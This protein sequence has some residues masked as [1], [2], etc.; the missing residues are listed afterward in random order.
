MKFCLFLLLLAP[1]A[2]ATTQPEL[3][4][5]LAHVAAVHDRSDLTPVVI[6]DLDETLI[7]STPR[8]CS[9][10]HQAVHDYCGASR[11]DDCGKAFALHLADFE[12]LTNRYD[13]S[14][15]FDRIELS[16]GFRR[17][18]QSRALNYYLSEQFVS[19]DLAIPGAV[20]YLRELRSRGAAVFFVTARLDRDVWLATMKS[21][22][23]LG[24][25]EKNHPERLMLR[26]EGES[27]IAFKRRA[28]AEIRTWSGKNRA[29]VQVLMENEPENMNAMKEYF[30]F[31]DAIFV[32]GAFLKA[33]HVKGSPIRIE[34]YR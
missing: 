34:D 8:R 25:A 20:E 10:F 17:A 30:P 23:Q 6:A 21:L 31:A 24:L 28:F 27:S 16:F 19:R 18:I 11:S 5:V 3:N 1:S 9:S 12:S 22:E 4:G 15:L 29:Q 26:S 33:E 2:W 13:P 14:P 7:N 32:E